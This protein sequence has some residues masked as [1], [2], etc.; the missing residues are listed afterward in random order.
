MSEQTESTNPPD[1][2]RAPRSL[3]AERDPNQVVQRRGKAA[4]KKAAV[5]G[6]D[7]VLPSAT[8]V[9]IRIPNL[10]EMLRGGEVPNELVPFATKARDKMEDGRQITTEELR[11][12]SDF[13]RWLVA[14]TVIDPS[15]EP[16]EVPELP[17]EDV[18]MVLEFATRQ[19]DLDALDQ[20][21]AGLH[22]VQDFSNFR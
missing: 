11:Q 18:D 20:H 2:S 13:V 17:S 9:T 3:K 8:E 21:I 5:T 12:S 6:H 19:R 1:E 7:I 4:W 16:D 15:I 10:I 14:R 22:L